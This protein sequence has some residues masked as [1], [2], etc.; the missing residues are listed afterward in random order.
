M[1]IFD[2]PKSCARKL[3][4]DGRWCVLDFEIGE[5]GKHPD[6]RPPRDGVSSM[7]EGKHPSIREF[8]LCVPKKLRAV[9]SWAT[10]GPPEGGTPAGAG[11]RWQ[12]LAT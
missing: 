9:G 1:E 4:W 3:V 5:R 11:G 8:F 12:R 7:V 2:C 6:A 10:L